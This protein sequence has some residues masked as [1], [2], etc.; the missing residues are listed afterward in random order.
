MSVW[1]LIPLTAIHIHRRTKAPVASS[2]CGSCEFFF[3]AHLFFH[4]PLG[5]RTGFFVL[6][7]RRGGWS[8][9]GGQLTKEPRHYHSRNRPLRAPP[10]P[11]CSL[12]TG[13]RASP[14]SQR[15]LVQ[16]T[17]QLVVP[18]LK[19]TACKLNPFGIQST[20]RCFFSL[21]GSASQR[22]PGND[23]VVRQHLALPLLIAGKGPI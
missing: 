8:G 13:Q 12:T 1:G 6:L 15:V 3:P 7:C 11:E 4:C 14:N 10:P 2:D 23:P 17:G 9:G 21:S 16:T 20:L 19:P 5:K 22:R 18:G